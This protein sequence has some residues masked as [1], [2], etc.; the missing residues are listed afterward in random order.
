MRRTQITWCFLAALAVLATPTLADE[1]SKR[2]ISVSGEGKATAPPD[3][4]TIHTGVVT[5]AKKARDALDANNSAMD[6]I[7]AALASHKIAARWADGFA[8]TSP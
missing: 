8:S 1:Q 5:Q 7:M 4:A 2:T 6:R 3:M